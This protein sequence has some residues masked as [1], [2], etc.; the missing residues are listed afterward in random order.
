MR[1]IPPTMII[2]QHLSIFF[3]KE[4][5]KVK[6]KKNIIGKNV[7][8][9]KKST[10]LR[11]TRPPSTDRDLLNIYRLFPKDQREQHLKRMEKELFEEYQ[12]CTRKTFTYNQAKLL[13][14]LIDREC[15]QSSYH[16][17]KAF[18]G[19]F[20][21]QHSGKRSCATFG[22]SLRKEW[23]PERQRPY[24]LESNR[25]SCRKRPTPEQYRNKSD[26]RIYFSSTTP[27]NLLHIISNVS[28]ISGCRVNAS[29]YPATAL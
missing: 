6:K 5:S 20:Q 29:L 24:I 16:L 4:L 21:R 11:Q 2:S 23:E 22:V 17:I 26:S 18:L 25:R 19:G 9:V 1:A 28:F 7:R 12:A 13:I 15:N 10:S 27:K 8:D 3:R 14:R